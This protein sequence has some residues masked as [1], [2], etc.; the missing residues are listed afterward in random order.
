M[1]C[2]VV[3]SCVLDVPGQKSWETVFYSFWIEFNFFTMVVFPQGRFPLTWLR[4]VCRSRVS[5]STRRCAT[6]GCSTLSSGSARRR[7]SGRCTLGMGPDLHN[8][9][10][11]TS[12][13]SVSA[14]VGYYYYII[15][16]TPSF[17]PTAF[18]LN[19]IRHIKTDGNLPFSALFGFPPF[20]IWVDPFIDIIPSLPLVRPFTHKPNRH[21]GQRY[22]TS[23]GK[24][25][26]RHMDAERC[27]G[28][29][30]MAD[31]I[32]ALCYN[33]FNIETATLAEC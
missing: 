31:R 22:F 9:R 17:E 6:G 3:L 13:E 32:S 29:E 28:W 27:V 8:D 30:D 4:R 12:P 18:I 24:I 23:L 21:K 5:P 10:H 14:P 20:S 25:S 16:P 33:V 19:V 2:S 15:T 26:V 7:A 11:P 1:F